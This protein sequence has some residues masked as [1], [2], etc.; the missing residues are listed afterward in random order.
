MAVLR[1]VII[2]K[3][4]L[5]VVVTIAEYA[6]DD[7]PKRILRLSHIDY[8]YFL[9]KINGYHHYDDMETKLY[10]EDF[11]RKHVRKHVLAIFMT[12][13]ETKLKNPNSYDS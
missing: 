1:I 13:I 9:S 6:S 2:V 7:A 3:P 4:G 8:K 10:L 12:Y 5:H 11:Y